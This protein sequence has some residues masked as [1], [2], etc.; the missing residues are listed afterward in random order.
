MSATS[1][2]IEDQAIHIAC[3]DGPRLAGRLFTP[4]GAEPRLAI[5]IHGATGVPRDYYAR[6]AAWLSETRQAAVL[7][8]DYRDTG[9][10][11]HRPVKSATASMGD[12][13]ILDQGAALDLICSRHPELPVEVIGHSLGGMFLPFHPQAHR[14]RRL[15][16]VASGPAHWTRHPPRYVPTVLAFW[17]LVG[18]LLVSILGYMPGR[19]LGMGADL[20]GPAYWQ[21]RRWCTSRPFYQVDWGHHMPHPKPERVTADVRLIGISDDEMIPPPVTRD[22]ARFYPHASV[23]FLTLTPAMAGVSSIGHLRI[24]SERCRKAWPQLAG[25]AEPA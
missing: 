23:N 15:T 17:Y 6:F 9:H 8:Y 2:V 11:A 5:I 4:T 7:I 25:L 16:A 19:V 21:W 20:P 1:E 24:F 12:W 10:S 13:G 3:S 14:V 18:P 22:L